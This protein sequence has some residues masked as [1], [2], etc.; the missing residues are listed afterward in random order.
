[1]A[2]AP[3]FW[4]GPLQVPHAGVVCD[5]IVFNVLLSGSKANANG[6]MIPTATRPLMC[7]G[8]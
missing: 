4:I 1:M 5:G 7:P 3:G 2:N 8:L 6:E